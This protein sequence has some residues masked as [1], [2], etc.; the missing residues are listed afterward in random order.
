M[1][2]SRSPILD[3]AETLLMMPDLFGW[4][5]TGRRAGERT[6]ASTTQLF[7]PNRG[8]WS[9]ELCA[10]FEIPRKILPEIIEPGTVLGPLRGSVAE[11]LKIGRALDGDR[12]RDPRHGERRGRRAGR[13][14]ESPDRP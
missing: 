1:A 12:P 6:D 8:D 9:N 3:A 11:E 4:L 10:G 13:R 7:D 14:G 2:R 5:L